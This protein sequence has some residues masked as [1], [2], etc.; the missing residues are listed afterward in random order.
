MKTTRLLAA[1]ASAALVAIGASPGPAAAS[2]PPGWTV[3]TSPNPDPGSDVPRQP[4]Q[5]AGRGRGGRR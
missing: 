1:A 4:R 3:V 2:R 5:R